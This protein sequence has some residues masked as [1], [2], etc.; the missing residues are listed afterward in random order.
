VSEREEP[1]LDHVR[2]A[3]REHD[4][5]AEQLA[6]E[7]DERAAEPGDDEEPAEPAGPG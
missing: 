7:E 1:D 6:R 5:R 3:L 2:E 4:E